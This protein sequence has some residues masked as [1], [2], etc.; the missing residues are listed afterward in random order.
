MI[1][2]F[3]ISIFE[4]GKYRKPGRVEADYIF[5]RFSIDMR[6]QNPIIPA[7]T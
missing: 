6:S 4:K 1:K 2:I 3:F 7:T 5:P